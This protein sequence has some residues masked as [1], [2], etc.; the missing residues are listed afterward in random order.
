MPSASPASA[1]SFLLERTRHVNRIRGLLALHGIREVKGPMGAATGPRPCARSALATA[2]ALA[3]NVRC[4]DG[5]MSLFIADL[6]K[7]FGRRPSPVARL[8]MGRR[9]ETA[10]AR[11]RGDQP[12]LWGFEDS[13]TRVQVARQLPSVAG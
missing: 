8:G 3:L 9:T 11:T 10:Q 13:D 7:V 1:L 5:L 6:V 4:W 12:T 2:R